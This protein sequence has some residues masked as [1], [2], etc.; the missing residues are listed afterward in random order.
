MGIGYNGFPNGCSDDALPWAREASNELDTKYMVCIFN[1]FLS[2]SMFVTLKWTQYWIWILV[3]QRTVQYTNSVVDR[4]RSRFMSHCFPVIIVQ[5]WSFNR[6]SKRLF[7][8][9]ISI[10]IGID[11]FLKKWN[12][13]PSSI[14]SRKMFDMAGVCFNL[15]WRWSC[16]VL[17]ELSWVHRKK[18]MHWIGFEYIMVNTSKKIGK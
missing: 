3:R 18:D 14:A 16:D 12:T 10:M 4:E 9:L 17:G 6:E 11:S 2:Y 7:I 8:C 13:S 15:W 5:K 1:V